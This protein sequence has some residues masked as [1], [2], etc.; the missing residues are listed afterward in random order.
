[1][2]GW[3]GYG[4][5]SG[6]THKQEAWELVKYLAGVKGLSGLAKAGLAQPAIAKLANSTTWLDG[7]RPKN[8]K[9]TIEEAPYVHF[10]S[11]SPS[12]PEIT[13]IITPKLELVW[14][15]TLTAQQA[16]N[17]FMPP[18][19]AKLDEINRPPYHPTLNWGAGF[20]GMLVITLLIM[21]WV[22]QGAR[23]D[24][25]L[26]RKIGSSAEAKAGYAFISPWLIGAIVFVLG[27]ML[28]SLMLAFTSWDM[29][30]PAKWVGMGNF[31]EMSHDERFFKSLQVTALYT[32][33][34][35]PLGVA[36]SLGLAL[37]LNTKIK[38]QDG[39]PNAVLHSRSRIVGRRIAALDAPF[40]SRVGTA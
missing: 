16:V 9:L 24:L 11:L 4:I 31:A 20:G 32:I 26:G 15:G 23:K 8:R 25:K 19:Q 37:L 40:Q 22:W 35:V 2:T 1:M 6:S 36:G 5:T 14:N 17:L 7:A 29:I 13:S 38:G 34:S 10:E 12:W 28:V 21:A 39:L 18:A 27:P 3:S 30:A 33:F